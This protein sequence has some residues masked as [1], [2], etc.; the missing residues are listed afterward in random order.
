MLHNVQRLMGAD[1]HAAGDVIYPCPA[2]RL[3]HMLK[4]STIMLSTIMLSPIMLS[5]R[6][7]M[8]SFFSPAPGAL[9]MENND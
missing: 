9:I 5:V 4:H 6:Y 8:E 7:F 3:P 2:G 1:A